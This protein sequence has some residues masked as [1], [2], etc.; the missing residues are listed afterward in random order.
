MSINLGNSQTI[1]VRSE[2]NVWVLTELIKKVLNTLKVLLLETLCI[3]YHHNEF[4][5][6]RI[7]NISMLNFIYF[8][9]RYV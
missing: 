1:W 6:L 9:Y 4:H 3:H 5:T 8:L 7:L 2:E